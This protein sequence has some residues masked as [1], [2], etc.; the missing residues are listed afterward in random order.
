[1]MRNFCIIC[2]LLTLIVFPFQAVQAFGKNRLYLTPV[3]ISYDG[4]NFMTAVT[5][6]MMIRCSI[7]GEFSH[8]NLYRA[9]VETGDQVPVFS[10]ADNGYLYITT[11]PSCGG[12]VYQTPVE[13]Y[14]GTDWDI[15]DVAYLL[16]NPQIRIFGDVYSGGKILGPGISSHGWWDLGLSKDLIEKYNSL[17][18]I[19]NYSIGA[20]STMYWNTNDTYKNTQMR[21]N[22]EQLIN[23]YGK[24]LDRSTING[25]FWL[26]TDDNSGNAPPANIPEWYASHPTGGVWVTDKGLTLKDVTFHGKG[27]I[28][29]R[30]NLTINGD[31]QYFDQN[32]SLGIIV[33]GNITFN[34]S[35]TSAVGAFFTPNKITYTGN[36]PFTLNGLQVASSFNFSGRTASSPDD[37]ALTFIYDGR[38]VTNP[39]PG[40]KSILD[41]GV[42]IQ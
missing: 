7:R 26:N 9:E 38:V 2:F 36:Q 23:E 19:P 1:M 33:L 37:F 6:Y 20:Q 25:A 32:S 29:V 16:I 5:E 3:D 35:S 41:L 42:T 31:L 17:Y 10:F 27:T 34:N 28:I 24:E 18:Q 39:P 12:A 14:N 15:A 40:F 30:D 13:I 11:S 8:D 4:T 22:I 21:L